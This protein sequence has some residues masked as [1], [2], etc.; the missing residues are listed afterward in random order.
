MEFLIE[1]K[2]YLKN[3]R[4]LDREILSFKQVFLYKKWLYIYIESKL[5]IPYNKSK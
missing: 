1:V 5:K 3:S 2:F 4:E